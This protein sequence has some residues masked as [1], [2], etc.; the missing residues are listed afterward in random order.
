MGQP[1]VRST[2]GLQLLLPATWCVVWASSVS[3][4]SYRAQIAVTLPCGSAATH[5]YPTLPTVV[6]GRH[7]GRVAPLPRRRAAAGEHDRAGQIGELPDGGRVA[8]RIDRHLRGPPVAEVVGCAP[9]ASGCPACR[10]HDGAAAASGG[11]RPDRGRGAL[12]VDGDLWILDARAAGRKVDHRRAP[13]SRGRAALGP[14]HGIG[15]ATVPR[16]TAVTLPCGSTASRGWLK[17]PSP[18][19]ET[20]SGLP[21]ATPPL[22]RL[23]DRTT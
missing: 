6:A 12:C 18:A 19:A 4:L 11:R 21:Q 23:A 17:T 10:L 1:T 15:A 16:Q 9:A 2:V 3:S 8:L 5:G 13:R 14:H 7:G 22:G 20:S